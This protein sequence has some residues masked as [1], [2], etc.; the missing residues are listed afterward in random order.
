MD[1]ELL[2]GVISDTH[3]YLDPDIPPIFKG[4][5]RIIHL[6]DIGH[7][8][9]LKRL[10]KIAPLTVI[11]GNHE[12][13]QIMKSYSTYLYVE[14]NGIKTLLTHGFISTGW[15]VFEIMAGDFIKEIIDQ[16][17][18]LIM[19]GHVHSPYIK[20]YRGIYIFC[21]GYA[22]EDLSEPGRSVGL[23]RLDKGKIDAEILHLRHK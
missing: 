2:I 7:P 1:R 12:P 5:D 6:G 17:V 20:E 22:G 21:P 10:E 19:H 14:L 15:E 9:I 8:Y 16:K 23:I 4:V 13:P 3:G 11:R 18:E